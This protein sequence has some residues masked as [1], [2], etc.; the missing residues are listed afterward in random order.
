MISTTTI[1]TRMYQLILKGFF[2]YDVR[3][4]LPDYLTKFY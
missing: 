2:V 3:F 4:N 1:I